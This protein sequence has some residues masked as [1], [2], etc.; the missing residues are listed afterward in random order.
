MKWALGAFL[1]YNA[2]NEDYILILLQ[3]CVHRVLSSASCSLV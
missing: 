3:C 1:Q 2:G